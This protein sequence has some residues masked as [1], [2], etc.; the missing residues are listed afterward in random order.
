MFGLPSPLHELLDDPEVTDVLVNAG[1]EVWVERRGH[2][3][4]HG[5][6]APGELDAALER[7]L[8]PLGRRLDRLS[9]TVDAR[10]DDGTRICAVIPPIAVDGTCAAFRVLRHR[11]W[12]VSD[13]V[14]RPHDV[15][16]ITALVTERS[17]VLVSGATGS[18]KTSLV[19]SLVSLVP[20]GQRVVVLEDTAE[21]RIDHPHVIRLEARTAT[22]EGRGL[23]TLDDLLRTSLRL[24][25][26]R[27]VVGEVRGPEAV[28]LVN[29]LNTGHA[30]S[31][32][33]IHANSAADA[34]HRLELLLRRTMPGV[35]H[36][37]VRRLVDTAIDVVVH[38]ERRSNGTRRIVESVDPADV[39]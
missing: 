7:I 34:I 23:V 39:G 26:D 9:P 3:S 14:D 37:T 32:S 22:A 16:R 2:L 29:A 18:G 8:A 20:H 4:P 31:L 17:N 10:L 5:L 38:V 13:F 30:G 36:T 27:L 6:L 28:T 35:D 21:L 19:G 15:E 1:T 12:E 11:S 25:P 33:T 24:R